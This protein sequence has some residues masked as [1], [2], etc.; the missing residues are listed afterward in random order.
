MYCLR[1]FFMHYDSFFLAGVVR[2]CCPSV[3]LDVFSTRRYFCRLLLP[4]SAQ[5]SHASKPLSVFPGVDALAHCVA[6]VG[7][8]ARAAVA[9][10]SPEDR[11]CMQEAVKCSQTAAA[12]EA[13]APVVAAHRTSAQVRVSKFSCVALAAYHVCVLWPTMPRSY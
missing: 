3:Y 6:A 12:E 9:A 8:A 7:A 4:F 5:Q 11:A 13:S 2:L 10:I 1:T